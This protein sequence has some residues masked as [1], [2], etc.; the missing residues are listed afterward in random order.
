MTIEQFERLLELVGG[1]TTI[2]IGALIAFV[3]F[4]LIIYLSTTGA[5]VYCI[6]LIVSSVKGHLDARQQAQVDMTKNPPPQ[7]DKTIQGLCV[8]DEAYQIVCS[9]LSAAQCHTNRDRANRGMSLGLGSSY[10][11][12]SDARWLDRV[13]RDAIEREREEEAKREKAS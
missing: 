5:V 10:M 1:A 9:T 11:H 6:K 12:T 3:L 13:V 4:K 7:P 2:G 8:N